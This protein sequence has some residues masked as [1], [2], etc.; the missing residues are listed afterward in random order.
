MKVTP[1]KLEGSGYYMVGENFI[2]LTSTVFL[3]YPCNGQTDGQTDGRVI[4]YTRYSIYAVMHKNP[5]T[6]LKILNSSC[7]Q[8]PY[9]KTSLLAITWQQI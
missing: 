4:A 6:K 5:M 8:R 2:V 9:W 3:I 7:G 1:Q